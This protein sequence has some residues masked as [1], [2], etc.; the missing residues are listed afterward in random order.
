MTDLAILDKRHDELVTDRRRHEPRWRDLARIL[1]PDEQEFSAAENRKDEVLETF[2]STPL[3]A[4]EEFVN[5]MFSEAMNPADRWYEFEIEDK[6]KQKFAPVKQ[7]LFDAAS[8]V[9]AS[10]GPQVAT[11][12]MEAPAA[13]GDMAAFG[14]GCLYQEEDLKTRSVIDRAVQVGHVYVGR[15]GFGRI[16]TV[17]NEMRLTGRQMKGRWRNVP[18]DARD[19]SNYTVLHCVRPN[20]DDY[21]PRQLG[22]AG[23]PY[24]STF[25]ARE[26]KDKWRVDGGYHEL[27]YHFLEWDR[28]AGRNYARGPGHNAFADMNMLDEQQRSSLTAL[29]FEAEP[30]LLTRDEDIL[31]AADIEPHAVIQ[32]GINEQGKHLVAALQRSEQLHLPMAATEATRTAI[33]EA[34]KFSLMQLVNRPQM[35]ATEF[36]GWKEE[37]LKALAPH[38]VRLQAGLATFITRRF[39]ILWRAGKIPPPPPELTGSPLRIEFVSPFAKAAKL[40]RARGATQ[41]VGALLPLAEVRPEALDKLNVDTYAEVLHDGFSNEPGLINDDKAVA[42]IRADRAARQQQQAQAEQQALQAKAFADVAHGKQASTLAA[43]RG[44]AA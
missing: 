24:A 36:A 25:Y 5:G 41:F 20:V 16:D 4:H 38:L 44:R 37:K 31:T 17:H 32:G 29:M 18:E 26:L 2:D 6:A 12:Y 43:S 27:P 7:W 35:T 28:R 21:D 42:Q 13:L 1:R 3:Y 40:A 23:K 8:T 11:F 39:S 10:L 30:M 14:P 22:P 15:D 19:D 9:A 34:F 33:R